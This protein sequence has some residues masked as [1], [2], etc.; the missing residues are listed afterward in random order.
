MNLA[1]FIASPHRNLWIVEPG[2]SYYVRKSLMFPGLIDLANCNAREDSREFGMWR[3]LKRYESAIPFQMEQVLN[4]ALGQHVERR[5]WLRRDVGGVPQ[6]AS[7][8]AVERYRE[9]DY[10]RRL[11][12]LT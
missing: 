9:T 8:L 11:Y 4:P 1:E 3:F 10:F 12:S 5:G 7:P 2:L 6:Y